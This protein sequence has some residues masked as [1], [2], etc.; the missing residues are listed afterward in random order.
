MDPL[1]Y[2]YNHVQKKRLTKFNAISWF[3]KKNSYQTRNRIGI[4]WSDKRHLWKI[5]HIVILH[6]KGLTI[7]FHKIIKKTKTSILIIPIQHF[8]GGDGQVSKW[9]KGYK[10]HKNKNRNKIIYLQ[11]ISRLTQK[12]LRNLQNIY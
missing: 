8:I 4:H 11:M 3:K 9:R 7:F 10:T 12:I 2:K 5:K 6:N 1:V